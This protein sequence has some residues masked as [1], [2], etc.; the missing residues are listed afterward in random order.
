MN[1]KQTCE[2]KKR[3]LHPKRFWKP[4]LVQT[5]WT[6]QLL[7][8]L[9]SFKH[10]HVI[11]Q[12][13]LWTFS[14]LQTACGFFCHKLFERKNILWTQNKSSRDLIRFYNPFFLKVCNFCFAFCCCC[15]LSIFKILQQR[16]KIVSAFRMFLHFKEK[17]IFFLKQ[18]HGTKFLLCFATTFSCLAF[19]NVEILLAQN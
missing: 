8:A 4:I 18:I 9:K 13:K 2:T 14:I 6:D 15:S 12:T 10:F 17:L 5:F 1:L 16:A 11:G 19:W 3:V 7:L